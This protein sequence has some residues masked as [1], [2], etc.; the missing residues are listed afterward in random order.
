MFASFDDTNVGTMTY[1]WFSTGAVTTSQF[2]GGTTF[3]ETRTLRYPTPG[4][5]NPVVQLEVVDITNV[6]ALDRWSLV[7]P[8]A[9]DGQ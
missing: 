1:P 6:N 9:L 2:G 7:P 8:A 4:T 3:P 5:K